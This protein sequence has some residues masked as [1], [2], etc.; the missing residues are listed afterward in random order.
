MPSQRRQEATQ[1]KNQMAEYKQQKEMKMFIKRRTKLIRNHW[2]N[3]I[4]GVENAND[5]YTGE[6]RVLAPA[7]DPTKLDNYYTR[8]ESRKD[9]KFPDR[10]IS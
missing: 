2:R 8:Q 3:G 9:S 7:A 5:A 1:A 10:F 6:N 4:T